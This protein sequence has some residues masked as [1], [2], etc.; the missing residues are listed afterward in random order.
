MILYLKFHCVLVRA[1]VYNG[2]S[3]VQFILILIQME[4]NLL[5]IKRLNGCEW[6]FFLTWLPLSS[7]VAYKCPLKK[8][9]FYK[10][11]LR[12]DVGKMHW[13]H[14]LYVV[15]NRNFTCFTWSLGTCIPSMSANFRLNNNQRKYLVKTK[16][17]WGT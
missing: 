12:L 11:L 9:P 16:F 13:Y 5:L 14:S 8:S 1:F 17:K 3:L 7:F 2:I 4:V 10:L 15:I 6:V